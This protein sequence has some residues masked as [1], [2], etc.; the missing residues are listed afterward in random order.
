M[1]QRSGESTRR[2]P[3]PRAA[4]R[5]A[6]VLGLLSVLAALAVPLL[7][8]QHDVTTLKCCCPCPRRTP[9]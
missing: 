6:V 9:R 4:R 5:W 7:P 1:G 3:A 8:V 2:D